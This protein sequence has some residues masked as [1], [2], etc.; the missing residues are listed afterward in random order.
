MF[1]LFFIRVVSQF[2][3]AYPCLIPFLETNLITAVS[4]DDLQ[5]YERFT[6]GCSYPSFIAVFPRMC[7]LFFY[8]VSFGTG[9]FIP[10][11]F[12]FYATCISVVSHFHFSFS[13]CYPSIITVLLQLCPWCAIPVSS[14]DVLSQFYRSSCSQAVSPQLFPMITLGEGCFISAFIPVLPQLY[15]SSNPCSF[16]FHHS[17]VNGLF[18]GIVLS[19]IPVRRKMKSQFYPSS[20]RVA[21][22]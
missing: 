13:Q 4:L 12:L 1:D 10:V 14:Q 15:P 16:Q 2:I 19:F 21:S 7:Y 3:T 11:L 9:C 20:I 18:F 6:P 17:F 22:Q 8:I 5:V